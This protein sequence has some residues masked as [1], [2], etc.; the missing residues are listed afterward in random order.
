[1]TRRPKSPQAAMPRGCYASSAYA[2]NHLVGFEAPIA[3]DRET[4][5]A[6]NFREFRQADEAKLG[7]TEAQIAETEGE[8]AVGIELREKPRAL[9]IGAYR[10]RSILTRRGKLSFQSQEHGP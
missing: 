8:T 5:F 3:L 7:L 4:K 9:L 6:A 10:N 2:E 1:M